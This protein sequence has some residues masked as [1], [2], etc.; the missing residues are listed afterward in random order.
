MKSNIWLKLEI[1]GLSIGL[2]GSTVLAIVILFWP[3]FSNETHGLFYG[4]Q[5]AALIVG[6]FII[7]GV[8]SSF[9]FMI[10]FLFKRFSRWWLR[11]LGFITFYMAIA[12]IG[13]SGI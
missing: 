9:L 1:I 5:P 11:L 10:N 3:S 7:I 12:I 4:G 2:I 6:L 13:S 8:L